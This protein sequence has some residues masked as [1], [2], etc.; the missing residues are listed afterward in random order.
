MPPCGGGTH[1]APP[2]LAPLGTPGV[3]RRGTARWLCG[4][5]GSCAARSAV[6][7]RSAG[8]RPPW[9]PRGGADGHRRT[10]EILLEY[11]ERMDCR[12]RTKS[13]PMA[14]VFLV[15]GQQNSVLVAR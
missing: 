3:G 14:F 4:R 15:G 7:V 2:C 8:E 9:V 5:L 1:P 10:A 6:K 12:V 13:C 11:D